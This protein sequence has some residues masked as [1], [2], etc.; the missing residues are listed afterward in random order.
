MAQP[1]LIGS[2]IERK[3]SAPV[4]P[5]STSLSSKTGFPIVQHRVKSAFARSRDE[6]RKNSTL[7]PWEAPRM[8]PSKEDF[9]SPQNVM[10]TS[11]TSADSW[12]AQI[13]AENQRRVEA[14][15][16]SEREE[17]V[18]QIIDRFGPGIADILQ[19][20]KEAR[21]RDGIE[22]AICLPNDEE[23]KTSSSGTLLGLSLPPALS[24]GGSRPSSRADRKL[25]F[26]ELRPRDVHVYE[27]APPSPKKKP[28]A[29]LPPSASDD[30]VISLGWWSSQSLKSTTPTNGIEQSNVEDEITEGTPEDIRRRYFPDAPLD[31]PNLSWMKV[32][33]EPLDN[34]PT[35][36]RFDL[37]GNPIPPSKSLTLPTHLGLHHHA[38]GAHAGYTLDDI[39]LLTRSTVPAQRAAMF[40]VLS[41]IAKKVSKMKNGDTNGLE[42]LMGKEEVLRKRMLSAGIEA[43]S[44]KGSVGA[45]AIKLVWTCIVNWDQKVMNIEDAE[46]GTESDVISSIPF[47]HFLQQV[48][49]IY[50]QGDALPES[51]I[52]LLAILHRLAQHSNTIATKIVTTPKL[53]SSVFKTHLMTTFPP[54]S[55]SALPEPAALEFLITLTLS[56]RTNAE[57]FIEY[58][59]ALLRFVT[60][61]PQDSFYSMTLTVSLLTS[62]L[63]FYSALGAYGLCAH[64]AST[65]MTEFMKLGTFIYSQSCSS[66]E[67]MV[68]WADLLNVWILCAIDPHQTTP[69]HDILWS[70][71][72]SWGWGSEILDLRNSLSTQKNDC[73]VWAALWRAEAAW[74]EGC[75]VNSV[76][77]GQQ[78]RIASQAMVQDGF[79]NGKEKQVVEDSLLGLRQLLLVLQSLCFGHEWLQS[80]T[81][82]NHHAKVLTSAI[83]LWLS[84]FPSPSQR[85][86]SS[87]PFILP[88][89]WISEICAQL[90]SH[91]LWTQASK[92][93]VPYAYAICRP[94]SSLLLSYLK[95]SRVLPDTTQD[96][97]MAQALSI[98]LRLL[99]GQEEFALS[100]MDDILD[101]ITAEWLRSKGYDDTRVAWNLGGFE[102]LKPFLSN[103]LR[104]K[105]IYIGTNPLTIHS[106]SV[107]TT[108]RLPMA[109]HL[110]NYAL[111]LNRDWLLSPLDHLLQSGASDV[112]RSLSETWTASEVELV[113]TVLSLNQAARD[114]LRNYSLNSFS[115]DREETILCCMK[116]FMLEHE[117]SEKD[118]TLEVFRDN[119]VTQLM[120]DLLRPFTLGTAK[121]MQQV[122][123]DL[124][125]A[126]SRFL[127]PS[128]PFFQYYTDFLAL[129]DAISFGH[130]LFTRLI[131][132]PASL[133]YGIDYR[134]HLW[135]DF[136]HVL[137]MV[138]IPVEQVLT[139]DINEYLYPVDTNPQ[140]VGAYLRALAKGTVQEFLQLVALHHV[141]CNIWPDLKGD[142]KS[143]NE[144]YASK[145]L[146]MV[147]VQA[148]SEVTQKVILY[149]QAKQGSTLLPLRCFE[150]FSKVKDQRWRWVRQWGGNEVIKQVEGLFQ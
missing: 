57:A 26:A 24:T 141:A 107:S 53:V 10:S 62:T 104:P 87:P 58:G 90:V 124:E 61:P 144:E 83:D 18:R 64:I 54:T 49:S 7:L 44:L 137:K 27:S 129:Y 97:W 16:D 4:N 72:V 23:P 100:I 65:A 1:G 94:L 117:Q 126:A 36:L 77:G 142:E 93:T 13:S 46:L 99:P 30:S 149:Q 9:E 123:D 12:R 40:G 47:E 48:A 119:I 22:N 42:E 75:R 120:E 80:V 106:I 38:N 132:P 31:D 39:F 63:R 130:P 70:Q 103:D 134:K 110:N 135:D 122:Q 43:M 19:R 79:S 33:P 138:R 105:E 102:L 86:T 136:S 45:R 2:V 21:E 131:L 50:M 14:M 32:A 96:L 55:D 20:A 115:L 139:A 88:F 145:L 109:T 146:K 82:L 59:D 8:P 41:G 111:P 101:S 66:R 71:V 11:R 56:S 76:K 74:L 25:R 125:S 108:Q 128:I 147:V 89:S 85:S 68:A 95:L 37:T 3:A 69:P 60:L 143:Q 127:G 91:S 73:E 29:L 15:T 67:L 52:E 98:V 150:G 121:P 92:N 118:S 35:P 17:E 28:L 34:T 5:P 140:M 6:M 84:F 116:V 133:R 78:E 113:R 112:F 81:T 148:P 114:I 51:L